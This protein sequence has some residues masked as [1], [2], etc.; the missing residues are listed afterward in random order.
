MSSLCSASVVLKFFTCE[1][2]YN[3]SLYIPNCIQKN[4]TLYCQLYLLNW[5]NYAWKSVSMFPKM[6]ASHSSLKCVSRKPGCERDA[7][8]GEPGPLIWTKWG[9][10]L[11]PRPETKRLRRAIKEM[12]TTQKKSLEDN[13]ASSVT[14]STTKTCRK[15]PSSLLTLSSRLTRNPFDTEKR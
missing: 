7:E 3:F 5:T 4:D 14:K 8:S 12:L 1:K 9:R 11:A 13:K 10:N 6:T 15:R 2:K